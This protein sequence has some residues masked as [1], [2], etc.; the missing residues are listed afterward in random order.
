MRLTSGIACLL[1]LFV[2]ALS[3]LTT[4]PPSTVE[5]EY[6]GLSSGPLRQARLVAL[7][8][9]TLLR[10]EMLTITEKGFA[11]ELASFD[12]GIQAQLTKHAFFLLE[13]MALK[14]L[15]VAE[16][17]AWAAAEKRDVGEEEDAMLQ[18]Y[19]R[20]IADRAAVTD[21]ELKTSYEEN[22]DALGGLTYAQV[23]K[24]LREVLLDEKRGELVNAWVGELSVRVPIEVDT[25]WLKTRAASSLDNPVDKARRAG[26]PA[27]IDFGADNCN[28][29]R[30]M[31]PTLKNL[32]ETLAEKCTVLVVN[33]REEEVL[34]ARYGVEIIPVQIFFDTDGKEVFRHVNYYS[35][36]QIFAKLAELGVK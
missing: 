1:V 3:G 10:T 13:Q 14:P 2:L 24:G 34:A 33:V 17:H 5:S 25:A 9:G 8:Q 18:A 30:M 15:L 23:E 35:R 4:E 19:L 28:P 31:A 11:D 12:T 36:E 29:C 16:A 32:Q 7:P 27:L 20:S 22:K 21:E 6:P 26:K